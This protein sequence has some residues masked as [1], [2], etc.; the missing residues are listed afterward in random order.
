MQCSEEGTGLARQYSLLAACMKLNGAE[1]GAD[2]LSRIKLFI[3]G[4]LVC[5]L[6]N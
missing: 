3:C 1:Y 6:N 5:N 2:W 4:K